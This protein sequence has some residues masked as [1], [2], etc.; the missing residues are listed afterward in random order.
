M[1]PQPSPLT[2]DARQ[3]PRRKTPA[4]LKFFQAVARLCTLLGGRRFYAYMFLRPGRFVVREELIEVQDLPS[5][6]EGFTIA[7]LSDLHAGCFLGAGDLRHVVA[8]V[9]QLD[10]DLVAITG[11]FITDH[12]DDA[13]SLCDDLE[14]LKSRY[15]TFA[16]FGN[17]DYRA[18]REGEIVERY[19]PLGIR[20]LRNAGHRIETTDGCLHLTGLED[21]EE[22]KCI[23]VHA[24]RSGLQA[25]DVEVLLCH[26]PAGGERLAREGCVLALSGHT[27]GRQIDLPYLRNLGPHHPGLRLQHGT[28][29]TLVNRG[30]GVIG[31]PFRFKSPAEIVLVTLRRKA[32]D[33]PMQ[34]EESHGR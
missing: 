32:P 23:D 34:Q 12:V 31:V 24:A 1:D 27:H 6:L 26:H 16:V 7:Q 21:L 14:A 3:A 5:G 18:R 20:F 22:G 9:N 30:L 8:R 17:H 25:G 28:T 13:W 15:G 19:G 2:I 33:N 10:V 29:T 11:D 4:R